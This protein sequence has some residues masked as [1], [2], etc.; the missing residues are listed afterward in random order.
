M[1]R[2]IKFRAYNEE[3][4]KYS[5]PFGIGCNLLNFTNE[6]GIGRIKSITDEVVEQYTGEKDSIGNEVYEGDKVSCKQFEP[7]EYVVVFIEGSFMLDFGNDCIDISF[8][9]R[10]EFKVTGNIHE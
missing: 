9:N 2:E 1:E 4:K 10:S 6:K 5:K 7:K 8:L 3:L